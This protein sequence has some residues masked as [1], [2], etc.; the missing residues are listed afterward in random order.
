MTNKE[1]ENEAG[2]RISNE[3]FK[4]ISTVPTTAEPESKVPEVRTKDIIS[5]ASWKCAALSA[6]LSLPP[7]PLGMLTIIPDLVAIWKIQAQMVSDI[8]ACYGKTAVLSREQMIYCLFRHA[9]SQAVKDLV[10]RVGERVIIK[11]ASLKAIQAVLQ[12]VGIRVAQRVAGRTISRWIPII[13][14]AAV[15]AYAKYDTMK[16][17]KT[18]QELFSSELE[19]ESSQITEEE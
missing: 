14:A 4:L 9:L 2:N 18:A 7:G 5:S 19:I 12:K 8:A 10:V 11:R 6:T 1:T 16:V 3:I 15:G 17:G 13:G